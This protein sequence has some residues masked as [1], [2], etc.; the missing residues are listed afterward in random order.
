MAQ[1]GEHVA[2]LLVAAR[3]GT[4]EEAAIEGGKQ[5]AAFGTGDDRAGPD[6]RRGHDASPARADGPQA[7]S[8]PTGRARTGTARAGSTRRG[9]RGLGLA[10]T[11]SRMPDPREAG[12]KGSACRAGGGSRPWLGETAVTRARCEIRSEK[13]SEDARLHGDGGRYRLAFRGA[14]AAGQQERGGQQEH[15]GGRDRGAGAGEGGQQAPQRGQRGD[16]GLLLTD[17]ADRAR[18]TRSLAIWSSR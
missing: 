1:R 16:G 8:G 11:C 15:A 12:M 6:Q 4:H 3:L 14:V 9:L 2:F 5:A 10:F 7:G 18:A 13:R 17:Q